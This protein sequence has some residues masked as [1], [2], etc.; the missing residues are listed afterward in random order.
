MKTLPSGP[1]DCACVLIGNGTYNWVY[2]DKLY[3]MLTRHITAGVR[4]HVYTEQ[5]RPVPAPMI[6]HGLN[7]W[8]IKGAKRNWW[9]KMELFNSEHYAGPLLYFDLD[10]VIVRNIDWVQQLPLNCFWTVKDFK[11]LWRPTH[12]G[13]NSSVMLF[14]TT[15]Y[16]HVY[17]QFC[18][19]PLPKIMKTYHGDQDFIGHVIQE[20]QRRYLDSDC[21]KSWRWQCLD[22]GYDFH[23]KKYRNPNTGTQLG[24][25]TSILVFH[26]DPKPAVVQDPIIVQNWC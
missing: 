26:G 20:K 14:D 12:R 16:Q 6:K 8:E 5:D 1:V 22:G 10:V 15:K 19:Q 24:K 9:Y 11:E 21:V 13:M 3:N 25:N 17:D 2:V 23:T 4:L 7:R 18:S